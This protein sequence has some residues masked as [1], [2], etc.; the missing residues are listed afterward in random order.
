M[1]AIGAVLRW[2]VTGT[3]SWLNVQT[4]GLVIFVVGIVALVAALFQTFAM[5]VER[6]PPPR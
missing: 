6:R 1:I 4:A 3:L 5:G 2:A